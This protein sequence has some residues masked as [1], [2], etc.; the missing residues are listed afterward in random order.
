MDE[1]IIEFEDAGADVV[2]SKPLLTS[3][4]EV[5][6]EHFKVHGCKTTIGLRSGPKG[7]GKTGSYMLWSSMPHPLQMRFNTF[8]YHVLFLKIFVFII[9]E[10]L[11]G[12]LNPRGKK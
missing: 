2:L 5:L 10:S 9:L 12:I 11:R 1:E 7:D 6:L 3:Q 8:I 4:L